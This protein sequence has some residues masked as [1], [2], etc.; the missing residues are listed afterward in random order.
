[1]HTHGLKA[2]VFVV[3]LC[4]F[5]LYTGIL[6]TRIPGTFAQASPLA[7]H[8][9]E[10][11]QENNCVAC[12][13]V[14]GLGGYLGPDLTNVYSRRDEAYIRAFLQHGSAVMPDFQLSDNDMEALV[15]Y[16]QIL[17]QSGKADPRSFKIQPNGTI[18][19]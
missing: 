3:L 13:Q 17:D 19:Q 8:G 7:D 4:G 11:W 1:M 16:L 14:F 2:V 5:L 6:Y 10:L 15:A 12:H 18:H 9:R